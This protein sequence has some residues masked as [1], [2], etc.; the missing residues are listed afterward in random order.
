MV[1]VA[2]PSFGQGGL[3]EYVNPRFGRCASFTFVEII[4]NEIKSVKAVPNQAAGAMGGAGI[5]A[6]QL[7]GNYGATDVIVGFLGPN[8]AQ[9]LM[10][11]NLN[12]YQAPQQQITVKEAIDLYIQGKLPK[13]GGSN[14]GAHY[15]MGAGGGFGMG[16][17]RGMG[18]G[19]GRGRRQQF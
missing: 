16:G 4:E 14:V 7:V 5:Q 1:I 15:G 18:G 9:G 11:L 19:G 6:A 8:A 2:V 12:L 17:G 13:I 10:S 3:N